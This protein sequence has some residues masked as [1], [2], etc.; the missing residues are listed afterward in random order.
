MAAN[1][2]SFRRAFAQLASNPALQRLSTD[3]SARLM[4]RGFQTG[5]FLLLWLAFGAIGAADLVH[6]LMWC[7]VPRYAAQLL[8]GG[9]CVGTMYACPTYTL[10]GDHLVARG[11]VIALVPSLAVG[12][13]RTWFHAGFVSLLSSSMLVHAAVALTWTALD[14][15]RGAPVNLPPTDAPV[16]S[17]QHSWLSTACVVLEVALFVTSGGVLARVCEAGLVLLAIVCLASTARQSRTLS[18]AGAPLWL[19]VC[20]QALAPLWRQHPAAARLSAGAP[21]ARKAMA[22]LCCN[23]GLRERLASLPSVAP[24]A[25]AARV[26]LA[27]ERR[28]LLGLALLVAS[29]CVVPWADHWLVYTVWQVALLYQWAVSR[30]GGAPP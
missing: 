5:T 4:G 25:S 21:G 29:V 12:A 26:Q 20:V 19:S 6:M 13:L 8:V 7:A 23:L 14:Y 2:A 3:L 15:T 22:M 27:P 24:A 10:L 17:W 1:T 28:A 9:A 18:S 11:P 30:G 16:K